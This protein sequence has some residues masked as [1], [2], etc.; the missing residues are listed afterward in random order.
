[1]NLYNLQ[2]LDRGRS[3]GLLPVAHG[4][5]LPVWTVE[6]AAPGPTLVLTTGVHGCEYV[7]I[8]TLRRLFAQLD[9]SA[10]RGR[11]VMLPLV[12][13]SGFYAGAKQIVPEDGKNI[14]RVFPPPA[15]GTRAEQIA[16]AI[17]E[18]VYP[19]A[20][21]L[22]DLH[23][24]DVNE[25]MTPLVFFP[26]QASAAVNDAARAAARHLEVAYRVPSTAKNGLYS[27]AAQQGIPAMLMEVGGLGRWTEEQ[28]ALELRS[29]QS[30]MGR[31]RMGSAP[32]PNHGQV[33]MGRMCYEETDTAG[34]W[35]PRC[36]VGQT[37]RQGQT[38]GVL[39]TLDGTTIR[40]VQAQWDGVVLYHT[41]SLGVAPG[42]AL[43]AYG[44]TI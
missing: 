27:Y 4:D 36:A 10:L 8:V 12:N 28:V 31:L 25:D 39:E 17:V 3:K 16:R 37:V 15:D 23:G 44:Q 2:V 26:S 22:L 6:G 43:V 18:Q 14:N 13:G 9:S 40:T 21:F 42:D 24:G 32:C 30:L 11:V 34:L 38:L 1:M 35:F 7:G 33:E 5:G 29:I 41:V 19:E 20:D